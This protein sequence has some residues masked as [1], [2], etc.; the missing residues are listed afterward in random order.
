MRID[1][2]IGMTKH[3]GAAV[4]EFVVMLA[5]LAPLF[6]LVP[7]VGK[8]SDM[9]QATIAA[10]R[11]AAWER[12]VRNDNRVTADMHRRIY[13]NIGAPVKTNRAVTNRDDERNQLWRDAAGN[14]L[15]RQ[16]D[17]ATRQVT[18]GTPRGVASLGSEVLARVFDLNDQGLYR[19]DVAVPVASISMAPFNRGSDCALQASNQTFLC[20]RRWNVI[21][22][23]T[24]NASGPNQ[25][26][27]RVRRSV[28]MS[29]F[30]PISRILD[31][32]ASVPL[33]MFSE[34]AGFEP[35]YVA[36]DVIPGDRLGPYVE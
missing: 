21:L 7:I 18:E 28:P 17:A 24:W 1:K 8:I 36:P 4:T 15:M 35:G 30:E 29:L 12:T 25:V 10:S 11:Y 27:T 14:W 23:D 31:V 16:Q 33:P 9:N 5:V 3:R 13:G 32:F 34:L 26:I 22:G 20:L 2:N 6:V 19:A